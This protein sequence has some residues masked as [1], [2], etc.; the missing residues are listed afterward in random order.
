MIEGRSGPSPEKVE[1]IPSVWEQHREFAKEMWRIW[2]PKDLEK[3]VL[4]YC[5]IDGVPSIEV[6]KEYQKERE[7]MAQLFGDEETGMKRDLF[8]HGTGMFKYGGDKYHPSGADKKELEPV[9]ESVLQKGLVP[10]RDQ[11]YPTKDVESVSFAPNY[12]YSRWYADKYQN[13]ENQLAWQFGDPTDWLKYFLTDSIKD[14]VSHPGRLIGKMDWKNQAKLKK[15]R[16]ENPNR[17]FNW[18]SSVNSQVTTATPYADIFPLHT[19]IKNNFG[20]VLCFEKAQVEL[21]DMPAMASHELRTDKV[22]A[23]KVIKAVI[24]PMAHRQDVER[25]VRG[26]GLDVPVLSTECVDL[27]HTKFDFKDLVERYEN[28]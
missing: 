15:E 20:I 4:D 22:V 19:D 27:H 24:A 14:T 23:P 12:F 7:V 16:E 8:F 6:Q 25:M 3:R 5:V 13:E 28:E 9:F 10:H 21:I 26:Q 2:K 18:V 11:W 1:A 17:V